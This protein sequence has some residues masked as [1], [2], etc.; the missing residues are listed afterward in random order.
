M[1]DALTHKPIQ[2]ST[3]SPTSP[4]L[5]VPLDQLEQVTKLLHDHG[6]RHWTEHNVISFNGRPP[7]AFINLS[8]PS[9]SVAV[10]ALLDAVP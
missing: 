10:Q 6:I 2:V 7:V 4:Y 5:M 3:E 1:T 9:D 8:K